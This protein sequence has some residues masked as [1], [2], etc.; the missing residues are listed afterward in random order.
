MLILG[1]L[2]GREGAENGCYRSI[3]P[4]SWN[5][6]TIFFATISKIDI[7][8]NGEFSPINDRVGIIRNVSYFCGFYRC[9]NASE[10]L[11]N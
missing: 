11:T 7:Q 9:V 1:N 8:Y 6:G 3:N 4:L 5:F 2:V 10:S